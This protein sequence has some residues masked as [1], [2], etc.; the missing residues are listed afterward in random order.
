MRR[1]HACRKEKQPIEKKERKGSMKKL[2]SLLLAML[3]MLSLAAD[4]FADDIENWD[5]EDFE[6]AGGIP[7]DLRVNGGDPTIGWVADTDD[8]EENTANDKAMHNRGYMKS[9]DVWHPGGGDDSMRALSPLRRILATKYLDSNKTYH[10]R[11][12]QVLDDP[13]RYWSFDY[14]ELCPKS[15][16]GSPEG[17]DTH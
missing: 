1:L 5:W 8:E 10:L 15:I 17:E 4:A 14:I 12:R 3:L 6:E 2:I 7:I 16:Y 9:T 13:D 11:F